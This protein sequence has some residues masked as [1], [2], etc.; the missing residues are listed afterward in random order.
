MSKSIIL[1]SLTFIGTNVVPSSIDFKSGLNLIYGASNTG[2][3]FALKSINHMFGASSPLPDIE[4]RAGYE[5]VVLEFEI[6]PDEAYVLER[7][8]NGGSYKIFEGTSEFLDLTESEYTV[9]APTAATKK[10]LSLAEFFL[11]KIELSGKKVAKNAHGVLENLSFRDVIGLSLVDEASIQ[12]ERSP[13]ESELG[14]LAQTRERSVFRLLMGGLDDSKITTVM[15]EKTFNVS[16][17]G[18]TQ[19]LSELLDNIQKRL[20]KMAVNDADLVDQENKLVENLKKSQSAFDL[21]NVSVREMIQE[22]NALAYNIAKSQQRLEE[23]H[24]HTERFSKLKK[25]YISDI[26]RLSA[27]EEVGFLMSLDSKDKC[28]YCGADWNHS[29]HSEVHSLEKLQNAAQVEIGKIRS[30]QKDLEATI[31][32]LTEEEHTLKEKIKEYEASFGQIQKTLDEYSIQANE[33]YTSIGKTLE[34]L[35]Q[36]RESLGLINQQKQLLSMLSA[37]EQS[38]KPNKKDMPTLAPSR[39]AINE[40]CEIISDVLKKW[41]FPG[42]CKVS[43]DFKSFDLE[44]D[45]KLRINNGK[46]IRAITHAAFKVGMLIYCKKN[47]LPHPGFIVIDTPLLTYRDPM[48][49]KP[50]DKLTDDEIK[51]SKTGL[52]NKFF[53]HLSSISSIG[54][55]IIFENIDPPAN[56]EQLAHVHVFSKSTE[57][58]R[59]GLFPAKQ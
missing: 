12:S 15:N 23:I 52:K 48:K 21:V 46:G 7:S 58:G 38:K 13:I 20:E 8:I 33:K 16:K 42:K 10:Q 25:I 53:E 51:I 44:I 35:D 26:R 27:I 11:K 55:I 22:K 5:Q 40:L 57:G 28:P 9:L 41:D 31:E 6:S 14:P 49:I 43:F 50:G 59:Y 30:Q 19:I 18:K 34:K 2:K 56:I 45:G 47:N 36:V 17:E 3:S 24:I 54:Q 37:V 29:N 32:S 1:K 4:E 39:S